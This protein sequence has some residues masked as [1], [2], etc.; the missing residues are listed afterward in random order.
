VRNGPYIFHRAGKKFKRACFNDHWNRAKE[1]SHIDDDGIRHHFHDFRRT[2][3]RN[4]TRAGVHHETAKELTGHLTDEVFHRYDIVD[5]NDL[6]IGVDKLD[7]YL[8]RLAKDRVACPTTGG[9][10]P[11]Q[12][13]STFLTPLVSKLNLLWHRYKK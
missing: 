4:L 12:T 1:V 3:V 2:A 13:V 10:T 6:Q 9:Q 5:L 11:L 8:K 7:L